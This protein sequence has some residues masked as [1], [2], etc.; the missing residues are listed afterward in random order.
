MS[1]QDLRERR[2]RREALLADREVALGR[3]Q[4]R[5]LGLR[6]PS[7]YPLPRRAAR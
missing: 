5:R 4:L 1:E 6:L 7:S 2:R 3:R